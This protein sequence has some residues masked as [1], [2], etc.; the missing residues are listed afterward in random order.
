MSNGP[1]SGL[2]IIEF[3]GIGPGPMAGMLLADMG[4]EVI[5]IE[6]PAALRTL[7]GGG[8]MNRGKRSVCL[9]LKN[10]AG[11][12]AA[13]RLICSSDALI[14]GYRPGVMERLGLGPAAFEAEHPRL[15]YGRVTGWG[16]T[17]PLAQAAGHDINYVALTGVSS[18]A[19]RPGEP[20]TL[21]ATMIGDMAGGAMFLAFGV[22]CA[23]LEAKRSG[24]GQVVD[25]AMIDG[26]GLLSGLV[27][28]LRGSGVWGDDP[29]RNF[30]LHQSPFY[31][32]FECADGLFVSLG[33]IEP[34]FYRELLT[35]LGLDDVDPARQYRFV[36]WPDLRERV[37]ARVREKTRKEW[38]ELMEGSDAC[39]APVLT[40]AEAPMHA[41]QQARGN[42]V[43]VNGKTQ[44]APAPRFS[45]TPP[46]TPGP[47]PEPGRDTVELLRSLGLA[48]TQIAAAS[49]GD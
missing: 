48:D 31:D 46:R 18:I 1:L 35:R 9:D 4:A 41:H 26:V 45:H 21:P 49:N 3:A 42:F 37:A 24:R 34:P 47:S 30:F 15:V 27:H 7:G 38:C 22:V 39:F 23:L 28:S 14:E 16:Q 36:D 13:R 17:G 40:M 33:A 32:C 29:A 19:S 10:E 2:R 11:L 44:P 43:Q 20:P 6:R 5:V 25:A 12:E 8:A